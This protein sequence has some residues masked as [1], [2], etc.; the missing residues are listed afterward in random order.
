MVVFCDLSLYI[1]LYVFLRFCSCILLSLLVV[2]LWYFVMNGSVFL[3]VS[4]LMVVW[5]FVNGMLSCWVIYCRMLLESDVDMRYI[6][7][8]LMLV[9]F[10]FEVE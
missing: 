10:C 5:M 9:D 3:V 2:F 7:F 6:V 1:F 4:N 8:F